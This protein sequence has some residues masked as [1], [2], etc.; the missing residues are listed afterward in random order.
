MPDPQASTNQEG[1]P[2]FGGEKA[3]GSSNKAGI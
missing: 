1:F 2:S 3:K